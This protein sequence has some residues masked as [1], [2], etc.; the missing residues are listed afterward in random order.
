LGSIELL[1]VG[2]DG[3]KAELRWLISGEITLKLTEGFFV[4]QVRRQN[5]RKTEKACGCFICWMNKSR[6]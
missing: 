1:G 2:L 6:S 4:Q 3:L 5:T